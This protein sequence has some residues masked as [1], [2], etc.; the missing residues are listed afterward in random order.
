MCTNDISPSL[1]TL[2]RGVQSKL[3]FFYF[4]FVRF[5]FNCNNLI[6]FFRSVVP[7]A[8]NRYPCG[9]L[10]FC[11]N[12][13]HTHNTLN[14]QLCLLLHN[15]HRAYNV[16]LLNKT[17]NWRHLCEKKNSLEP[18]TAM[19]ECEDTNNKFSTTHD[20]TH[21]HTLHSHTYSFTQSLKH[22]MGWL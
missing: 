21:T 6:G 5:V 9:S 15:F 22:H 1:N 14:I 19:N 11:A 16:K 2:I 17:V 13:H 18:L 10:V 4:Y 20:I 3:C 8:L 12:Y 7:S